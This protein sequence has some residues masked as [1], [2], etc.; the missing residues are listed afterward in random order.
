MCPCRSH[1]THD[2]PG[3]IVIARSGSELMQ[4]HRHTPQRAIPPTS[5]VTPL[6]V[7]PSWTLGV[8]DSSFQ[9]SRGTSDGSAAVGD[10]TRIKRCKP[11][12]RRAMT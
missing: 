11:R 5:A 1:P 9:S 10:M 2:P 3:Q 12:R 6:G 7:L 8:Y 4:A